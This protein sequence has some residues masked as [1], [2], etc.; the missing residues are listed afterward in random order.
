MDNVHNAAAPLT[1]LLILSHL[2]PMRRPACL[3]YY[4]SMEETIGR[5]LLLALTLLGLVGTTISFALK[6]ATFI[7]VLK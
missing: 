3:C 2:T 5:Y 1:P 4:R 7:L 6:I